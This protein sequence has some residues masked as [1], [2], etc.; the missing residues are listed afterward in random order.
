MVGWPNQ[1]GARKSIWPPLK[2]HRFMKIGGCMFANRYNHNIYEILYTSNCCGVNEWITTWRK[3]VYYTKDNG[4]DLEKAGK[5]YIH[6]DSK[7]S[8]N[9]C[10]KPF[11]V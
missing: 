7:Y 3:A 11:I 10:V 9:F 4:N 8:L 5:Y 6:K 1:R 2:N